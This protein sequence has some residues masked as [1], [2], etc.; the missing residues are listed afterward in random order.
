MTALLTVWPCY[1]DFDKDSTWGKTNQLSDLESLLPYF[2]FAQ[3]WANISTDSDIISADELANTDYTTGLGILPGASVKT[4]VRALM[5]GGLSAELRSDY[6]IGFYVLC[7][8]TRFT[9]PPMV[10]IQQKRDWLSFLPGWGS[11]CPSTVKLK[12]VDW[13]AIADSDPLHMVDWKESS[14]LEDFPEQFYAVGG[15]ANGE[16]F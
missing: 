10:K 3:P 9:L 12:R 13:Q 8:D 1:R 4:R 2:H 11:R 16:G 7:V 6:R 14:V 5:E 15:K